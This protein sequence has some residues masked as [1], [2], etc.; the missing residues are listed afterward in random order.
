MPSAVV[1]WVSIG[2]AAGVVAALAFTASAQ[3]TRLGALGDSLTDEYSEETYSYAKNWTMQLVQ[4]RGVDMGPT[5]AA[6]GTWGEPRRTGYK[7]N[8]AR[9]G[10]DSTTMLSAG[11]H[12][13][14]AAQAAPSA[15]GVTHAVVAI[16]A[17]D[18][19][20]STTAFF[21]IY[22]GLWSQTQ[23]DAYAS[24]RV[25]DVR[26]AVQTLENAGIRPVLGNSVD[27]SIAPV[28]RQFYTNATRRNRVTAAVARVNAGLEDAARDY[29]IVLLDLNGLS[30]AVF[31]TNTALRQFLKIGN[32]DIQLLNRDTAAHANPLAGFVDDGA[33]PHTTVQGV[34]A[35]AVM[36]ALNAGWN[37]GYAAFSDQEILSH[38]GLAYGGSDTLSAQVGSYAQYVRDYRCRADFDESGTVTIDDLFLYLD[39]WFTDVPRAD[40]D[41][42]GAVGIDDLFLFL[43]LWFAGCV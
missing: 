40:M 41:G 30:T 12:T 17:N 22:W 33:H 35:N 26:T 31:G 11:Q 27:F 9:Y 1:G 18:F 28:T 10:A 2:L 42:S 24:A 15:G 38:A 34:F 19:S 5:A 7:H 43:A 14:L 29:R 4:Y 20:P 25:A 23:I 8:W 39:A 37:A 3:V 13:G 32:V 6:G 16:G 36:A 21:N